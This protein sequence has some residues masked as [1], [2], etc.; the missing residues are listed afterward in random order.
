MLLLVW[1]ELAIWSGCVFKIVSCL[2]RTVLLMMLFS[3]YLGHFNIPC[4]FFSRSRGCQKQAFP[5]FKMFPV[6]Q[7]L[8]SLHIRL[9]KFCKLVMDTRAWN[10]LAQCVDSFYRFTLGSL[11][12]LIVG[13]LNEGRHWSWF[14]DSSFSVEL[15]CLNHIR[16]YC[17]VFMLH[18][19]IMPAFVSHW[20]V[21]F[22]YSNFNP[23]YSCTPKCSSRMP[24]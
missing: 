20:V 12:A 11:T 15:R 23:M 13:K 3:Q 17:S 10:G 9:R 6:S 24:E 14:H 21:I 8:S 1:S 16:V 4:G 7:E 22:V 5:I 19:W 2:V 18:Q